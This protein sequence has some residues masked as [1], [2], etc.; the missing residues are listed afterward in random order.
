MVRFLGAVVEE[1]AKLTGFYSMFGRDK[2]LEMTQAAWS[3]RSDKARRI[4]GW[5]PLIPVEQGMGAT[6]RWYREEGLL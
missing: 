2:A 6:L 1:G 3:C 4:L 5:E